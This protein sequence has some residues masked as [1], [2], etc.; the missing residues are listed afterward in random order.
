VDRNSAY[1]RMKTNH[2]PADRAIQA[3]PLPDLLPVPRAVGAMRM[4]EVTAAPSGSA[5]EHRPA[6]VVSQPLVVKYEFANR[7]RELITLPLALQSPC[8]LALAFRCGS[9]CGLD[10]ISGRAELVGGDVCDDPGL[11]SSVRGM[12]CCPAQVSGRTHGMAAGRPSLGHRDLATHPGAGMLDRLTRPW[13][14]RLS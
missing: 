1:W 11:A 8:G 10:G 5:V 14:R 7:R 12:P 4:R 13:V 2:S 3:A 6:D 9:T